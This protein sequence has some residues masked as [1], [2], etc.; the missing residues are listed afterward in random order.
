MQWLGDITLDGL[1][2]GSGVSGGYRD[3]G[4][5]HLRIL[6]DRQL[7][8]GLKTEQDDQQADHSG[9]YRAADERIGKSHDG[10]SLS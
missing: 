10:S 9:Q 1:G 4:I 3:Q 6:P 8:P 5:F 2:V 7:A